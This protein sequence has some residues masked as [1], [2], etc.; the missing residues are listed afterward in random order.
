MRSLFPSPSRHL[1]RSDGR[2]TRRVF[3][4]LSA[5][6]LLL[7]GRP[8]EERTGMSGQ[9]YPV[10]REGSAWSPKGSTVTLRYESA[11][12]TRAAAAHEV[13][14]LLPPLIARADSAGLRRVV[15]RANAPIVQLGWGAAIYREWRFRYVTDGDAWEPEQVPRD[16]SPARPEPKRQ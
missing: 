14:D 15:V 10:F 11:A 1:Q 3:L 12:R 7:A 8:T 16:V 13:E 6:L 9:S 4:L 5:A 2:L